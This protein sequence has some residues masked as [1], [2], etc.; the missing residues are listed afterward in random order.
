M[1][2]E[3]KETA[4]DPDYDKMTTK[5]TTTTEVVDAPLATLGEVFSFAES[6]KTRLYLVIGLFWAVVAGL[7][8]P[9]SIFLFSDIMG[10]IS[11]ITEE[12]LEPILEMVYSLMVL[13]VI[14]LEKK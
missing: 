13:G 2:T 9:A 11:A 4:V 3:K 7:A 12:G 5:E 1:P 8:L 6:F 10:D 14:A